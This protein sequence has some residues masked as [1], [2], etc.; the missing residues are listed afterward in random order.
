VVKEDPKILAG[1]LQP[2]LARLRTGRP[3]VH[4]I[5]NYV[6]VNDVANLL[7]ACGASPVMADAEEEAAE[8]AALAGALL[9]NLGTLNSRTVRSMHL[10]AA[11]ANKKGIPIVLDPVGV[12]A[13]SFRT[14]TAQALL[15]EHHIALIRGNISEIKALA[16][17]LTNQGMGGT[18]GV[19][20]QESDLADGVQGR[21]QIARKLARSTS[22]NSSGSGTIVVISGAQDVLAGADGPAF[23]CSN[24]CPAMQAMTGS[25]CMLSALLAANAAVAYTAED[26]KE[27]NLRHAALAGLAAMG[28]CGERANTL[29]EQQQAGNA[30]FRSHLIDSMYRLTRLEDEVKVEVAQD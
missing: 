11:S 6:T 1:K 22:K 24:G 16:L 28:I 12:G 14:S 3:L 9:I 17:P 21:I 19:D 2:W 27:D 7:L 18:K 30:S 26:N 25:G 5:T 13:T 15:R 23:V 20:A 29:I 4:C 8:M 10:A